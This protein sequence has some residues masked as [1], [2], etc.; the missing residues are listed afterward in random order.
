MARSLLGRPRVGDISSRYRFE[1][2]DSAYKKANAYHTFACFSTAP[3]LRFVSSFIFRGGAAWCLFEILRGRRRLAADRI[4]LQMTAA[5]TAPWKRD[6]S[7]IRHAPESAHRHELTERWPFSPVFG[8]RD[9]PEIAGIPAR[10][11]KAIQW[12]A[13]RLPFRSQLSFPP[14]FDR[15]VPCQ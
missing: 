10:Y 1:F 11:A 12:L 5:V 8:H 9:F 13:R 15:A 4:V 7:L 2:S 14:A 6:Q 3:L